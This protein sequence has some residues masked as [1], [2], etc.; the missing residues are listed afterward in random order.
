MEMAIP[1]GA[2]ALME[3]LEAAGY[4]AWAVGGCVRDRLLGL[5]PHDWDL[6]TDA[7]PE[8]T[9]RIFGNRQLV[10][11]GLKHG[12]VAVVT[13]EG[14]VEIT[15]FRTEGAYTDSRHPGWV[16]FR[17]DVEEDLARRD[18]TVNAMAYSPRRGLADPFGGR[19][20]LKNRVLRA[21]GEPERRFR[22]DGL[23][24]L[25]GA[26][27][28]ARFRLT[29]EAETLRAM[30]ALAPTL[31][32]QARE[33]VYA[34][35]CQL[36]LWA[37]GEDLLRF[38][39]VVTEAIPE[40][41]PMVGFLQH[42]P[43]H[44]YDVYTHTAR[45]VEGVPPR[46]TLRWAALLHDVGK[47]AAF[48]LDEGG[49]GHFRGHAQMG[50]E[51]AG[52][53]LRTLRAP[54]ALREEVQTLVA[55]RGLT[56]DLGRL[57]EE[58]P[59]RRVLRRLG[60]PMVRALLALDRADDGGKGTPSEPE[61]FDAFEARLEA[62]LSAAPCLSLRDLAVNGRTLMAAGIP[63]GPA[64]GQIL[65]RLLEEVGDG[66]LENEASLLLARAKALATQRPGLSS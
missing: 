11:A 5:E 41:K 47:P 61:P 53:I 43:H 66:L 26:R 55:C 49:V 42:N 34:E 57:G 10:L 16:A 59:I 6:C 30:T 12:T 65:N 4:Q 15:T 54:T 13:A 56:R 44:V 60:E 18:F 14:P 39:P 28:A 58:R 2:L 24:I 45:V 20:D 51:L 35:L 9:A 36:L 17:R 1:Q 38:A 46:L 40:L 31:A 8:E 7:L 63:Q 22:E 21:V 25:R 64:L 33:R 23:R 27:F 37:R 50:A 62:I 48:T 52:E 32:L 3:A 29:P 19:A